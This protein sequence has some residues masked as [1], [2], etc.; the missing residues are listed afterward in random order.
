MPIRIRSPDM[1][2]IIGEN[3]ILLHDNGVFMDANG[4]DCCCGPPPPGCFRPAERC[5][6]NNNTVGAPGIV[7]VKCNDIP[8]TGEIVIFRETTWGG[9]DGTCYR[10]IPG[11]PT[12]EEVPQ[13]GIL[14]TP[15]AIVPSCE[16]C[17]PGCPCIPCSDRPQTITVLFSISGIDVA[18]AFPCFV[19]SPC[20]TCN[21][22]TQ[23][24]ETIVLERETSPCRYRITSNVTVSGPPP[25]QCTQD[26]TVRFV[27]TGS[28][29]GITIAC[30]DNVWGAELS[31]RCDNG[32]S[33]NPSTFC[34]SG[35]SAF[36]E[37]VA[38]SEF[39]CEM[40]PIGAAFQVTSVVDCA[41]ASVIRVG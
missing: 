36:L 3:G 20:L 12:F 23:I 26:A 17:C 6:C 28:N 18:S 22:P 30:T 29:P 40:L 38:P 19:G 41:S 35:P 39:E 31:G 11:S 21:C 13:G 9:V 14:V 5:E 37:W 32:C 10:V 7:Y 2:A 15:D 8:D 34:G 24:Q 4:V 25:G 27:G 33:G 1:G 16:S